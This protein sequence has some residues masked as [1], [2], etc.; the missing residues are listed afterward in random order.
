[1]NIEYIYKLH[2]ALNAHHGPVSTTDLLT[3]LDCSRSTLQRTL[4]FLRD[5][6]GAPIINVPNRG[7]FYDQVAPKFE[8][9][10][11]WFRP[12]EL[13]ALLVMDQLLAQLQP[14]LLHEHMEAVRTKVRDLL[15]RGTGE[16]GRFPSNRIRILPAHA[17]RI[18]SEEL[19]LT[20]TAVIERRKLSF[21]YAGRANAETTKRTVSPQRLVHYRDQWY[22]DC[23]DEDKQ[24]LRTFSVDRMAKIRLMREPARNIDEGELNQALTGGYGMFAGPAR[25]KAR[26]VFTEERARWVA[27]EE[28]HPDQQGRVLEDGRYELTVPYSAPT[29]L[30]GEI[31]R[32]GAGVKVVAPDELKNLVQRTLAQA[33][34]QYER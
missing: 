26:L 22:A 27:D 34:A 15:D 1:M 3:T 30:V 11:V 25:H 9:P 24:S 10:G 13:E 7:Y 23:W 18:R 14:G 33:H 32:H 19:T 17:R 4:A 20:A 28:W 16:R 21:D 29:E 31:L 6:L 8:L 5:N 2:R 12:D